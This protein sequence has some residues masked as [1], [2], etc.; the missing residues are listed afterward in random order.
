M[1]GDDMKEAGLRDG[2][3]VDLTSHFQSSGMKPEERRHLRGFS[4]VPYPIP[5]RCLA[6]YFPEANVLVPLDSVARY[7]NTPAYKSIIVSL[8]R[9]TV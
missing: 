9:T 4:V 2:D 1:N 3:R 5:R 6:T 8:Q 7:S